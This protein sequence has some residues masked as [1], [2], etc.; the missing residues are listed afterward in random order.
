MLITGVLTNGPAVILGKL[1]DQLVAGSVIQ[2]GVVIPFILLL[3]PVILMRE[4]LTV[5]LKYLIQNIATQ[6]DNNH[7][8]RSPADDPQKC[9]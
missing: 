1:V 2:F 6:T 5:I 3:C 4:G 9:G 8:D 7:H